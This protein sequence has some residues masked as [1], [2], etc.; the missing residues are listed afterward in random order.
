M[1]SAI[2][3]PSDATVQQTTRREV[4]TL[5]ESS[6]DWAPIYPL[7]LA[8]NARQLSPDRIAEILRNR[9]ITCRI[10]RVHTVVATQVEAED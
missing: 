3:F 10:V 9:G 4:Q 7:D 6:P 5:T 2:S 1:F 8:A